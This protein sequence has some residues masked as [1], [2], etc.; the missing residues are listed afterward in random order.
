MA[1]GPDRFLGTDSV[2]KGGLRRGRRVILDA[3][4]VIA[5]VLRE[6]DTDRLQRLRQD[7]PRAGLSW[8]RAAG[9]PERILLQSGVN[10][11]AHRAGGWW[12]AS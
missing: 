9:P 7:G 12:M 11:A 4:A 6:S 2:K 1:D 3:S 8:R 10:D 5:V